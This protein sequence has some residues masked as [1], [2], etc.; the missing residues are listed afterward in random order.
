MDRHVSQ[1]TQTIA[2]AKGDCAEWR[3]LSVDW[4]I[5][6]FHTTA[7]HPFHSRP[8]HSPPLIL[9]PLHGHAQN[10][11]LPQARTVS[12]LPMAMPAQSSPNTNCW[13]V[14]HMVAAC[15]AVGP[16]PGALLL[17]RPPAPCTMIGSMVDLLG[18]R[19]KYAGCCCVR[20]GGSIALRGH[21]VGW[22]EM[23]AARRSRVLTTKYLGIVSPLLGELSASERACLCLL[24]SFAAKA[25]P[26]N[27]SLSR[28]LPSQQL[29]SLM[30]F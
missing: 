18:S 22:E 24:S 8:T 19:L 29:E 2:T 6:P 20:R 14:L 25:S 11:H 12:D 17:K 30:L 3:R 15:A 23:V 16:Q 21:E 28:A 27:H 13:I 10:T 9:S 26:T 4:V 7:R 1:G 5:Y